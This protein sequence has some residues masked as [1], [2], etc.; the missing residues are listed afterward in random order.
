MPDVHRD[1]GI[2]W[3]TR[4]LAAQALTHGQATPGLRALAQHGSHGD[5]VSAL[6]V[7]KA[8]EAGDESAQTIVTTVCHRLALLVGALAT[9]LDPAIVVIS[10][11]I[12]AAGDLLA[13]TTQSLLPTEMIDNPPTIAV[14]ALGQQATVHGAIWMALSHVEVHLLD[15]LGR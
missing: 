12:A 14:S 9:L 6:N 1:Y 13:A 7:F 5:E 11:G 2:A 10:G 8:A 4:E 3:H 15:D